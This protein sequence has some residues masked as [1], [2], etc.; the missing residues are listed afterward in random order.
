MLRLL[1]TT[2]ERSGILSEKGWLHQIES[3]R[4]LVRRNRSGRA[5]LLD[6]TEVN[7]R[8]RGDRINTTILQRS[9]ETTDDELPEDADLWEINEAVYSAERRR[10]L[11][12]WSQ[13]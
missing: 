12:T 10:R 9:Q 2:T 4:A 7:L 1:S 13:R 11:R 3:P 8:T 6:N 5:S